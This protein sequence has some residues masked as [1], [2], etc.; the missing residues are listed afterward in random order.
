M[1]L[2][3]K[4]KLNIYFSISKFDAYFEKTIFPKLL[5]HSVFLTR[6]PPEAPRVINEVLFRIKV[7]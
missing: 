3:N 6:I 7:N 5:L 1:Y 2:Y 4:S